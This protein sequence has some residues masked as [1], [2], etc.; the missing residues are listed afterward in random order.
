MITFGDEIE[1][2]IL[3]HGVASDRLNKDLLK[4]VLS[5]YVRGIRFGFGIEEQ[6]ESYLEGLI[7][8]I[9]KTKA[10]FEGELR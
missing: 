5:V 3:D 6:S 10:P 7:S 1:R 9:E 4:Y 8:G 2:V